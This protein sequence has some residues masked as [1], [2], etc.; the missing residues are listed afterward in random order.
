[1]PS[2]FDTCEL[3]NRF[4]ALLVALGTNV[5]DRLAALHLRLQSVDETAGVGLVQLVSLLLCRPVFHTHQLFF[6]LVY[7]TN[8]RRISRMRRKQVL[9]Y[10]RKHSI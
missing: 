3:Q 7:T 2:F 9:L 8:C 1:M 4:D 6:K 10:G 5:M